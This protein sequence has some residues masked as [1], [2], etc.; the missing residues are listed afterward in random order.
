MGTSG[1]IYYMVLELG[2]GWARLGDFRS[3]TLINILGVGGEGL[4]M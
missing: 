4:E 1:H 3:P 2:K